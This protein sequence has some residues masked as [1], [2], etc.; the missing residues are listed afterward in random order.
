M[1]EPYA[2][3]LWLETERLE[4]VA[5]TQEL[6]GVLDDRYAAERLLDARLPDGWP[7][8]ELEP[9]LELYAQW[10]ADDLRTLGYGPWVAIAKDERAVAGSAGFVGR[11]KADGSV[12]IGFGIH[13][14][15]R[16]RGY[17]SEAAA[18]LVRW[19]LEQPGVAKVVSRCDPANAASVRVHEKIGMTRLGDADGMIR[20]EATRGV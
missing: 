16:N 3:P 6:L 19:V 17:A 20:W 1:P 8:D 14:D 2:H 12:E 7:D 18:T 10:L 11:P 15:F 13:P 4:L 5:F 9:L